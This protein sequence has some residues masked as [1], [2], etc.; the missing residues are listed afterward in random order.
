MSE[1]VEVVG[2]LAD[3]GWKVLCAL[4]VVA[5]GWS[6]IGRRARAPAAVRVERERPRQRRAA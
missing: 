3:A 5:L 4:G 2:M 6:V 1:I